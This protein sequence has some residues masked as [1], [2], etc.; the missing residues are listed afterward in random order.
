MPQYQAET[1]VFFDVLTLFRRAEAPEEVKTER[2]ISLDRTSIPDVA[3]AN[4]RLPN[5]IY[6]ILFNHFFHM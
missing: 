1:T 5:Y 3:D 2:G 6:D 4:M